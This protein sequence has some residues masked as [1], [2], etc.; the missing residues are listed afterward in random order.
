MNDL[1][2]PQNLHSFLGTRQSHT[3]DFGTLEDYKGLQSVQKRSK[4]YKYFKPIE[5]STKDQEV[6]HKGIQRGSQ[7]LTRNIGASER[8]QSGVHN[9][10]Y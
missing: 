10:L 6:P 2:V 1:E 8:L 4:F 7:R 9:A 3:T 5:R